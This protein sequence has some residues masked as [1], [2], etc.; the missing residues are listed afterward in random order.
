M[1]YRA[2]FSKEV[3]HTL[4]KLKHKDRPTFRRVQK[5]IEKI[6]EHPEFGKPLRYDLKHYRREPLGSFVL[7]YAIHGD[8]ILFADYDHHNRIY[9]KYDVVHL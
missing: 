1:R 6:L 2:A 7:V 4:R 5:A 8:I 3:H 9:K